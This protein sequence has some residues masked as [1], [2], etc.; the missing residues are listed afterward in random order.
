[1]TTF[2]LFTGGNDVGE[3]RSYLN[4]L[5]NALNNP[6]QFRGNLEVGGNLTV[7]GTFTPVGGIL[8]PTGNSVNPRLVMTGNYKPTAITDGT[9][10]TAVTTETY[11][12]QLFVPCHMTVT[13]IAIINATAVAGNITVGLYSNLGVPI[14]AAKSPSTAAAG[15]AAYQRVPFAAPYVAVGPGT[16]YVA[17]QCD[18]GGMKFRAHAV[19]DFGATKQTGQVY[20]TFTAVTVPTTFTADVG[21]IASLY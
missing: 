7:D 17:L 8:N 12:A 6:S 3:L 2:P 16:H 10:K 21:P 20:G 4:G 19:G 5:V 15:T 13:G 1:M 14:T 11:I 9:E 18:N